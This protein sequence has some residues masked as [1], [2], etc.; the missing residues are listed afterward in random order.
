MRPERYRL[1]DWEIGGRAEQQ[2]KT[3][4]INTTIIYRLTLCC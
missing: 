3:L 2:N 1:D 4:N